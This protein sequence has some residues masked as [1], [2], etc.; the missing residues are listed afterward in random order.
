MH[1]IISVNGESHEFV[2]SV[3]SYN[4]V[5]ALAGKPFGPV[6]TVTFIGK[7]EG[8]SVNGMLYPGDVTAVL[9]GMKIDVAY[10]GN[11]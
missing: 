3:I 10:T 7:L 4:D 6:Y 1:T 8:L 5:I 11:A 9:S 2:E